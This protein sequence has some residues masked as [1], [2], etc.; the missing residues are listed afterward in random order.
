MIAKVTK[1]Q[2]GVG[3]IET[4]SRILHA[5]V[6]I[7]RPCMLRD[8]AE[9]A[10]MTPAQAHAYLVSFKSAG[11]VEQEDGSGLYRLGPMALSLGLVRLRT[12]DPLRM[13]SEAIVAF[14]TEQAA[15]VALSVW[16]TYGPTIVQVQEGPHQ[17]HV[18]VRAGTVFSI[19]GTATGRVFAAHLPDRLIAER[20][21]AERTDRAT[22]RIGEATTLADLKRHTTFIRRHGFA[23]IEGQPVPGVNAIAAPVRDYT[24]QLQCVVTMIGAAGMLETRSGGARAEAMLA[25]VGK[26]SSDLGYRAP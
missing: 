2:R 8:L 14:S 16:G 6:T 25:F 20:V 11:L 21:T 13:A 10:G 15:M 24:G 17:L 9:H 22:Q 19:T 1:P 7:G 3:A 26:L 5:F 23:P 18:N 12:H 4:G